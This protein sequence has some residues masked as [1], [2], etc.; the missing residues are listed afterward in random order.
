MEEKRYF[1]YAYDETY[2]GFHGIY[3]WIF[4]KG[5]FKD[6]CEYGLDM[7]WDLIHSYSFLIEELTKDFETKEEKEESIKSDLAYEVWELR[8]DAPSI[9]ELREMDLSPEEYITEFCKINV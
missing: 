4:F 3:D 2:Q 1:V 5:T 9:E 7:S 8:D 6:A